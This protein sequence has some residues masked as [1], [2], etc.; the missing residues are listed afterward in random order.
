MCNGLCLLNYMKGWASFPS[1]ESS[2]R[3]PVMCIRVWF[4]AS[5]IIKFYFFSS[6]FVGR[7][8]G[9]GGYFIFNYMSPIQDRKLC[10]RVFVGT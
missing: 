4:N 8:S 2:R 6:I 10:N 3:W 9:L 1:L 5:L 7:F